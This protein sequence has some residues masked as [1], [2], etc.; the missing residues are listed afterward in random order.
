MEFYEIFKV[1]LEKKAEYPLFL[2]YDILVKVADLKKSTNTLRVELLNLLE[3]SKM[4]EFL[5]NLRK[6]IAI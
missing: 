1:Q 5:V 6:E 4:V 2:I 3:D